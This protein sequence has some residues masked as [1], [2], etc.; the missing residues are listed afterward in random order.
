MPAWVVP[1]AIRGDLSAVMRA[2]EL[3]GA[4]AVSLAKIGQAVF[5]GGM[6]FDG[7]FFVDRRHP[8]ISH[9]NSQCSGGADETALGPDGFQSSDCVADFH[10]AD[11]RTLER[12]HFAKVVGLDKLDRLG[13]EDRTERAIERCRAAAALQMAEYADAGFLAGA[14]FNL[15]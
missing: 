10:G 14:S 6:R 4:A 5:G 8:L 1:G 13:A 15:L 7:R 12:D 9:A 3:D 11:L 2:G